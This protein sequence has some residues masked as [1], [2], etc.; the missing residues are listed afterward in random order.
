MIATLSST[1][2][3]YLTV[4]LDPQNVTALWVS[5]RNCDGNAVTITNSEMINFDAGRYDE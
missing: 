2:S 1:S 4:G 3:P 5:A